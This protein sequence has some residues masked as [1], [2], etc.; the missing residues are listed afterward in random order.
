[1]RYLNF[2]KNIVQVQVTNTFN[3]FTNRFKTSVQ[4][5]VRRLFFDVF[6]NCK[7]FSLSTPQRIIYTKYPIESA[8]PYMKLL[9]Y[10]YYSKKCFSKKK[11]K[12]NTIIKSIHFSLH[13][14]SK[15]TYR[16][17]SELVFVQ[18]L[19]SCLFL[20]PSEPLLKECI[21]Y[22]TRYTFEMDN[23]PNPNIL[24]SYNTYTYVEI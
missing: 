7:T 21:F 14:K 15:I 24:N 8:I 10:F 5:S 3:Y 2:V 9:Q 18:R 23:F 13:S 12:H 22:V 4:D 11:K 17:L 16:L 6:Q 20:H 1:M 19:F